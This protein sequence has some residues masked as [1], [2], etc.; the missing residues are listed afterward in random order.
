MTTCSGAFQTAIE[1]L[2]TCVRHC[3]PVRKIDQSLT[4]ASSGPTA[5]ENERRPENTRRAGAYE[6]ETGV[7]ACRAFP[8][9]QPHH[10][11]TSLGTGRDHSQQWNRASARDRLEETPPRGSPRASYFRSSSCCH[12]PYTRRVVANLDPDTGHRRAGRDRG[13][14]FRRSDYSEYHHSSGAHLRPIACRDAYDQ[15]KRWA[16]RRAET[17]AVR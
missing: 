16:W 13:A 3:R 17:V 15:P 8:R 11:G 6:N 7:A 14:G 2:A 1:P 9:I 5:P 12:C 10:T 4:F